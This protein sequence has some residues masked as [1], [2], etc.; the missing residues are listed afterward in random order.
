MEADISQPQLQP[1]ALIERTIQ[2]CREH[3]N[4]GLAALVK[5]IGFETVEWEAEGAVVRDVRGEE[6]LDFL[7]GF[8]SLNLGHRHPRVVE[9]V[10][11]QLG[12]MAL[13]SKVLFSAPA[14]ELAHLLAGIAPGEL[15]F[16]FFCNSG[17]E[18]VEGALKL[19]RLAT[20]RAGIVGKS[21]V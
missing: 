19:A 2:H 4:P 11:R 9:A 10:E 14:A 3:L 13:S 15:Q 12:R 18:A 7:G 8:G 1:D 17:A 6:Y 20:G 16:S 5:F 21:V